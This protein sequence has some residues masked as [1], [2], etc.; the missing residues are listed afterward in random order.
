MQRNA[1]CLCLKK[2]APSVINES[3]PCYHLQRFATSET[4]C[5]V[6]WPTSD[7]VRRHAQLLLLPIEEQDYCG[8]AIKTGDPHL[9]RLR[10]LLTK[11][12]SKAKAFAV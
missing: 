5:N 3:E 11:A 9:R 7:V 12:V 6:Q 4:A 1:A 2:S 8:M 10:R